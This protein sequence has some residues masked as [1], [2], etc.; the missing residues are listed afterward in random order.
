MVKGKI[1]LPV[2]L[3]VLLAA[4]PLAASDRIRI[5]ADSGHYGG[6]SALAWW[7]G[8]LFTG[9][10]DGM[11]RIWDSDTNRM[12]DRILV[13]HMEVRKIAVNPIYPHIAILETD[14]IATFRISVWDWI[15]KKRLF[16]VSLRD[17][18]IFLD[19]SSRGNFLYYTVTDWNSITFLNSRTG[20]KLPYLDRGFGI[21]SFATVSAT[22][23]TIM[24][25][26][27]SGLISYWDINSGEEKAQLRTL[28]EVTAISLSSNKRYMAGS[29]EGKLVFI[30]LT[31][32]NIVATKDLPNITHTAIHPETGDIA[33]FTSDRSGNRSLSLWEYRYGILVR[34]LFQPGELPPAI[35]DLVF[36]PR[37]LYATDLSGTISGFN[38]ESGYRI[39]YPYRPLLPVD[40]LDGIGERLF[41]GSAR[42]IVEM[43]S[44][45]LRPY[46]QRSG[47]VPY[48]RDIMYD[49]PLGVSPGVIAR[50]DGRLLLWNRNDQ[51]GKLLLFDP[52]T[53]RTVSTYEDFTFP[54]LSVQIREG[55]IYTL[56]RNGGIQ[57]L[58]VSTLRR[59]FAYTAIGIQAVTP[60]DEKTV[61][62]GKSGTIRF[63]EP[64]VR[65]NTVT[66]E[67]VP[68]RDSNDVTF[69]LDYDQRRGR[70]FS[71]GLE[72]RK[73]GIYTI[74][75]VHEGGQL[76]DRVVAVA[77]FR[78]ED[79]EAGMAY[80]P[81][82]GFLFTSL[83]MEGVQR[84]DGRKLTE[85]QRNDHIPRKLFLH[86]NL[87]FAANSDSTV[88]VWD[89]HSGD[90][91]LDF[92]LYEDLNWVAVLPEGRFAASDGALRYIS[93]Y[94]GSLPYK[95]T[96]E[97]LRLNLARDSVLLSGNDYL[98]H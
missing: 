84:W 91:V 38:V 64:L 28:P 74:L 27:P 65:I 55:K 93:A 10:R 81:D 50:D 68:I 25:Y 89:V 73:D 70:L 7:S 43:I 49:N 48:L 37:M 16:E 94:R 62:A 79:I 40:S 3:L 53:R 95:G 34:K 92:Y 35:T 21:V 22:E 85:F 9:G 6:A 90:I 31:N 61:I 5:M 23:Q 12:T 60:I 36:S 72:T 24:T 18:P 1:W 66:G 97:S 57:V 14:N 20:R 52:E 76:F 58:D 32:G 44:D 78:G 96:L 87:L 19:Y 98:Q 46:G 83:G 11:I 29:F 75:K 26:N 13:S 45:A 88:T 59:E 63:G 69:R 67:T 39:V 41:L 42:S 56:E 8:K 47:S 86:N 17:M 15:E 80:D 30:D 82:N 51:R 33:C 2:L 77:S 54:L 4:A 71:L